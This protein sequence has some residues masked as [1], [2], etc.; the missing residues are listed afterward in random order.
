MMQRQSEEFA[1]NSK[2][3]TWATSTLLLFAGAAPTNAQQ[4]A[5][6]LQGQPPPAQPQPKAYTTP[7]LGPKEMAVER[8]KILMVEKKYEAGIQAYQDL[9]KTDP[10]N[11]EFMNMIGIMYL[12]LSNF[13]QAKK[14]LERSAKADKKYPSAVNNL[15]MVYYQQKNYRRAI[16]EYQKAVAIDPGQAGTHANLGYAYYK[17]KKYMEAAEQ[18][19]K[20]LEIDPHA[21]DRNERVGTMMQDRTVENHGLF[22]F[23]MA[24]EYAQ[25]GDAEHCADYL[26]KSFDE[27]YKDV[28][29]AKSDPA[30]KKVLDDPAVQAV[31]LLA[32]PGQQK[33][34]T[35]TQPGA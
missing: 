21:F 25:M 26:R 18:F 2:L 23:M 13:N 14:Y 19:R 34:A 5:T 6:D 28:V 1:M 3:L 31:L 22:F 30:F 24:K 35:T 7:T 27:G 9:L 29:K 15:G 33:A 8:A 11:A 16:R 20:A 17:T 10:N 12:N 4:P 32:A